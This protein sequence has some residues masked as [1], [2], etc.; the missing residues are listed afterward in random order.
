L[1]FDGISDSTSGY[2][3]ITRTHTSGPRD[4]SSDVCSADH[5]G[6]PFTLTETGA[7]RLEVRDITVYYGPLTGTYSFRLL[8]AAAAVLA[9]PARSEERRVGNEGRCP[10]SRGYSGENRQRHLFAGPRC[11]P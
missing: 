1:F 8:D 4:C 10:R 3:R 9:L 2:L 7:Y 5:S 6:K 11:C